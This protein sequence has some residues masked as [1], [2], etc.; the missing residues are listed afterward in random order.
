MEFKRDCNYDEILTKNKNNYKGDHNEEKHESIAEFNANGA[1]TEF[2]LEAAKI[3][4]SSPQQIEEDTTDYNVWKG[5]SLEENEDD[6]EEEEV[7]K[8]YVVGLG[9]MRKQRDRGLE[10]RAR[11]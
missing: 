7:R 3:E 5:C 4:D 2:P 10:S 8:C 1:T 6:E 11:E 9:R